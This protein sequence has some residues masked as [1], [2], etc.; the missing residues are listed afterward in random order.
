MTNWYVN[1]VNGNTDTILYNVAFNIM[2]S[3]ESSSFSCVIGL[4]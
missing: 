1:M 4:P 3:K 2:R